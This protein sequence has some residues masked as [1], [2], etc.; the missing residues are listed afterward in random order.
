MFSSIQQSQATSSL[1]QQ[2]PLLHSNPRSTNE[3]FLQN[4]QRTWH[5]QFRRWKSL[6]SPCAQLCLAARRCAALHVLPWA[7]PERRAPSSGCALSLI[8]TLTS[9][10]RDRR[11]FTN[12]SE[13]LECS[14][15][16]RRQNRATTGLHFNSSVSTNR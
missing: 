5:K 4:L 16:S 15:T 1:Q 7:V 12:K 13:N 8:L 9:K 3:L 10:Q 11:N 2:A 6:H 14:L